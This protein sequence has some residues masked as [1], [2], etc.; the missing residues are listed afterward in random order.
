MTAGILLL[1]C[2]VSSPASASG[3]VFVAP[4]H[5]QALLKAEAT[6]IDARGT[7]ASAP[8]LPGARV[9]DW[10]A[11]RDGIARTGRLAPES[12]LRQAFGAAGIE[13]GRPVLVYGAAQDGWGEEG[14]IWWTLRYLGHP[15]VYILDGGVAAWTQA[16]LPTAGAALEAKAGSKWPS[17]VHPRLRAARAEVAQAQHRK[18]VLVLDVRTPEE[19]A[20]STPYLSPRGGH[21]PGAQ[22]LEWRELIDMQGRLRPVPELKALFRAKGLTERQRAIAYCTG[23]VRSAFVVA[24]LAHIGH[25][26]PANYDGSWW[27]WSMQDNLPVAKD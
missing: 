8:Y 9:I 11:L 27:D 6:V 12:A 10:M 24:V 2:M 14:R 19:F 16:K 15:K 5:A 20:G 18:D 25:P 13:Q 17:T 23:G 4:Q 3:Q 21:V 7:F 22:H 1:A 26:D